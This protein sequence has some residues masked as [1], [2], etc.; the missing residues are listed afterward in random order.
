MPHT[1]TKAPRPS[2][3]ATKLILVF[4]TLVL[5]VFG[6]AGWLLSLWSSSKELASLLAIVFLSAP[7]LASAIAA[8]YPNLS[9]NMRFVAILVMTACISMDVASNVR[10]YVIIEEKA[11]QTTVESQMFLHLEERASAMARL[12]AA[13]QA[14]A[15]VPNPSATGEIRTRE[16]WLAVI[17]MRTRERDQ[18]LSRVPTSGEKQIQTPPPII[19]IELVWIIFSAF[20]VAVVLGWSLLASAKQNTSEAPESAGEL[21]EELKAELKKTRSQLHQTRK[22]R[23]SLER[24][25]LIAS[26]GPQLV[27]INR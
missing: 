6:A 3:V 12:E 20:S 21:V 9:A 14:L 24:K 17:E 18:A 1:T 16:T 7:L 10:S 22:D 26:E 13:E 4:T 15:N 8:L 11:R 5:A 23:K 27:A 25:L 19:S 2:F